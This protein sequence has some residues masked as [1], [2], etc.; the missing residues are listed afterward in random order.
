ML[1][2]SFKG[3]CAYESLSVTEIKL[4]QRRPVA[5][6]LTV[7]GET[8]KV[9]ESWPYRQI[10]PQVGSFG[11]GGP[12]RILNWESLNTKSVPRQG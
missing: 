10:Q 12:G 8:L 9:L 2:L 11:I 1:I 6:A 4:M 7:S 5:T 3:T